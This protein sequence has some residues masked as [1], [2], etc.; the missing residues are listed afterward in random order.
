MLRLTIERQSRGWSKAK[1]GRRAD[2]DAGLI[3]KFESRRTRPYRRE[4]ERLATALD[5]RPSDADRLLDEI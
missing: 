3:S 5:L 1:L 4:L 2:L